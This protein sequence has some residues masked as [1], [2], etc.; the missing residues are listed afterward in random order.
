MESKY[1]DLVTERKELLKSIDLDFPV[2]ENEFGS[3]PWLVRERDAIRKRVYEIDRELGVL[4]SNRVEVP[5][6]RLQVR[7]FGADKWKSFSMRDASMMAHVP[8]SDL[9]DAANSGMR[10]GTWDVRWEE[11]Q[12]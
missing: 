5:V 3:E 1:M 10:T 6:R 4:F 8:L 7:W 9:I 11:A 2:N 12:G